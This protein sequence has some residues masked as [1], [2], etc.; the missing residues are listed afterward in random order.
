MKNTDYISIQGWMTKL[1]LKPAELICYSVIHGFSRDGVNWFSGTQEYLAE[2]AQ[3]T[4]RSVRSA[5]NTL[6][7]KG[8][9]ISKET[10]GKPTC[11]KAKIPADVEKCNKKEAENDPGSFFR[12]MSDPGKNC[13]PPRKIF[14]PINIEINI[15]INIVIWGQSPPNNLNHQ[16]T[17]NPPKPKKV[18]RRRRNANSQRKS[19]ST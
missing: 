16:Q 2:W 5:I 1:G 11:Y 18:Q 17:K 7:E 8:L 15:L 19:L 6:T 4:T 10:P 12:P 13:L 9:L 3:V 14:P